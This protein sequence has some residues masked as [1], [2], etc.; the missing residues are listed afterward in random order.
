MKQF[1][2]IYLLIFLVASASCKKD[3]NVLP[4]TQEV[5]G[6]I[7][8]DKQSAETA[9]NGIYYLFALGGRD[10]NNIQSTEWFTV[11]EAPPSLLSE[12]YTGIQYAGTDLSAHVIQPTSTSVSSLWTYGYAIVNAANGFFENI[13]PVTGIDAA[14]KREMMAEAYFL[15]AYANAQLLFYF[16][17]YND[18]TSNY[19]IPLRIDF[20]TTSNIDLPRSTVQECYNSIFADLDSAIAGLPN[21]NTYNYY[22]NVWTA[23]LLEARVLM[24]RGAGG[25][26]TQAI[27]LCQDIIANGPF[28]LEGNEQD[29]FQTKGLSSQEVMLGIEPYANQIMKFQYYYGQYQSYLAG[30]LMVSLFQNDPRSAWIDRPG[31]N[32][33]GAAA[34]YATKYYSGG[35]LTNYLNLQPE[36]LTE[37]SYVF[38]LTEAYLLEAEA[39]TASGGS[40]GDAKTLLETVLQHAG[41]TDFSQVNAITTASAL[42]LAIVE[43]E[44]KN[45]VGEAGQDWLAVRRLPLSTLQQLIPSITSAT[46]LILPIPDAEMTGNADLKGMQNPGYGN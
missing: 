43:E 36:T 6:N 9:L 15:R 16:G 11:N 17:Q 32:A 25:D 27:S 19:G 37:N 2:K 14:D 33:Y 34:N 5:N 46:Q 44:M 45:F 35:D 41:F 28:A 22:A 40:L 10:P 38:R 29:I 26:Y 24:V 4:T 20:I 42:Q 30:T 21:L 3:L 18:E 7:I 23:K 12:M 8:V 13:A 31:I 39:I 1:H